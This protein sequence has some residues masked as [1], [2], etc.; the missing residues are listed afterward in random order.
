MIV[1]PKPL[2][3]QITNVIVL[4]L[5]EITMGDKK[6]LSG[7][8]GD[9]KR[10]YDTKYLQFGFSFVIVNGEERPQCLI[11]LKVLANDTMKP[12]KLKQHLQLH[13]QHLDKGVDFFERSQQNVKKMKMDKTGSFFATNSKVVEASYVVALEIAKQKKPHTVGE[14]LVKPCAMKMVEIVLGNGL[15][16]KLAAV[17]LSDN[18][19]QRRIADMSVDIKDQVVSEIKAAKFGIFSIQLDESTDVS[20][21]AQL[22]VF[23]R[24]V[25]AGAI[26]EEFLFCSPLET[27]SKG[28]D[29]LAKVNT[30][31][32]TNG[33]SWDNVCGSCTDGAPAMLG[34]KSGFQASIKKLNP[35]IKGIHCMIHRQAL[36][37]PKRCR[38]LWVLLWI[39]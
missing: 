30:F 36:A 31:F 34:S 1:T 20:S 3:S 29:I 6:S 35:R 15:E 10:K 18:T 27:T 22:L 9:K 32:E 2:Y 7:K 12:C 14:T 33:L 26:K 23:V 5:Q 37:F 19:V 4:Y 28:S 8:L 13:P 16:K 39:K 38:N 24:Y 11:C 17:S 25:H 21:C